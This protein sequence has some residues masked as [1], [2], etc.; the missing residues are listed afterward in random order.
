MKRVKSTGIRNRS[1]MVLWPYFGI[2]NGLKVLII[3]EDT[4]PPPSSFLVVVVVVFFYYAKQPAS[5]KKVSATV[6]KV[7]GSSSCGQ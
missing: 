3:K 1:S 2:K 5:F 4:P 7:S 6:A